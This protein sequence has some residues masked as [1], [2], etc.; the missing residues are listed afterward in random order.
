MDCAS[1]S[2][3]VAAHQTARE[4]GGDLVLAAVQQPVARLLYLT[5]RDR[6]LRIF[7][8]VDEAASDGTHAPAAVS[9]AP[10]QAER[11]TTSMNG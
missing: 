7:A 11:E 1:L 4:A 3:L 5:N 8:S 9:V 2:A 6:L 10:R